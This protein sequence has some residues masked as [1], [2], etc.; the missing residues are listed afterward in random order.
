MTRHRV[1]QVRA[2]GLDD[3]SPTSRRLAPD[4]LDELLERRQQLLPTIASAALTWIAVGMTS[5][6]LWLRLTWSFGCTA[7]R[8]HTGVARR[9]ITSFAFMLL[10][11]PEPVWNTSTGNCAS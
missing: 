8:R 7:C 3:V 10:L 2:P 5:L 9:A 1:H 4:R 6:L 11:V